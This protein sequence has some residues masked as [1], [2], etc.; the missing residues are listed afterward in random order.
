MAQKADSYTEEAR[1]EPKE[2]V[3]HDTILRM[4]HRLEPLSDSL[5]EE[6]S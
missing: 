4:D 5:W 2:R 1:E 6:S 3:S